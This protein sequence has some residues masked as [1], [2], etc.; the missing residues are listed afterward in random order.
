MY[1]ALGRDGII[2]EREDYIS[3]TTLVYYERYFGSKKR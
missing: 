1:S 3:E 2:T